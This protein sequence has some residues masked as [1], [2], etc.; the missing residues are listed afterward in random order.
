[1]AGVAESRWPV[2][3]EAENVSSEAK[4]MKWSRYLLIALVAL[5][6]CA[7]IA[8]AQLPADHNRGNNRPIM[9]GIVESVGGRLQVSLT[10]TDSAR[11]VSGAARISLGAGDKQAEVARFEFT[12]APQESRLFPLGS[13]GAPGDHYTLA[14]YGQAG[15]LIFIKNAP[16]KPGVIAAPI[17]PPPAPRP[18][19]ANPAPTRAATTVVK[20]LTVKARLAPE[21]HGQSGGGEIKPP[22]V[23]RP[24]IP[25]RAEINS[26][27]AQQPSGQVSEHEVPAPEQLKAATARVPSPKVARRLQRRAENKSQAAERPTAPQNVEAPVSVEAPI[28]DEPGPVVLSFEIASPTPIINASLSVSAN[29]F[30]QRQAVNVQGSANVEFKLPENFEEPKINYTLTDASGRRLAQGELMLEELRQEDSV[31]L[32]DVKTDKETYDPGESAHFIVTLEGRSPYGYLLEVAA[33]DANAETILKDSRKG[34]YSKG[35][36]IQE[37]RVEIPAETKGIVTVEFKAFGIL[38]RKL[39]GYVMRE[40]IINDT[41]RDKT[42]DRGSILDPRSSIFDPRSSMFLPPAT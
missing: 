39:F 1:M 13:R 8:R 9:D 22:E 29:E 16:V 25:P 33:K 26:P 41:Q 27:A 37:F 19:P 30:K 32:S 12:L 11:S 40:I 3:G 4:M 28:S 24:T 10:N 15:S 42:E 23:I 18:A 21:R 36:A 17:A 14:I 7:Q 20:E 38:T 2:G 34:V 5:A 31:S 35:K 6:A